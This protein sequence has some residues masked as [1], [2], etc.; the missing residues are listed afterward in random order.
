MEFLSEIKI[1]MGDKKKKSQKTS[2]DTEKGWENIFIDTIL[3]WGG[4]GEDSFFSVFWFY[5]RFSP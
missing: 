5:K 3:V 4:I 2:R 1:V